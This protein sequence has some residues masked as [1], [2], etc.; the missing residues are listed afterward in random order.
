MHA[1]CV[2]HR[3]ARTGSVRHARTR[4]NPRSRAGVRP[5]P[6]QRIL[7]KTVSY[8]LQFRAKKLVFFRALFFLFRR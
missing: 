3:H 6:Y 1:A 5:P 4:P 2:A 7:L 8:R